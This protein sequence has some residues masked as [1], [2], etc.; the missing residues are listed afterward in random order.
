MPPRSDSGTRRFVALGS[1]EADLGAAGAASGLA[2]VAKAALCLDQQI[3]PGLGIAQGWLAW[4]RGASR[5]AVFLPEG[6]QFWM[7]NRSRRPAPR[8]GRGSNLAGNSQLVVLEEAERESGASRA[9]RSATSPRRRQGLFAIEAGDR[10]G[11]VGQVKQLAGNPCAAEPAARHRQPGTP[12]VDRAIATIRRLTERIAIVAD[13]VESLERLLESGAEAIDGGQDVTFPQR[14]GEFNRIYAGPVDCRRPERD[15]VCLP[16]LG[17][18]VPGDG[19]RL[20]GLLAGCAAHAQD[21]ENEYLRDQLDPRVWWAEDAPQSFA[22][23]CVP[24][25]GTVSLG[26]FVTDILRVLGLAPDAAIGYSLG[27]TTALVA[28]RA[29]SGRDEMLHR[30]RSSPLF[31]TELAGPCDAARRVWGIPPNEPVNWVA[32]I[33]PRSVERVRAG[34]RRQKPRVEILIKNTANE[35]VIGGSR[36]AVE[37]RL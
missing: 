13:G 37:E 1:I 10:A 8:R 31:Q 11:L 36:A 23:H 18:P 35:T 26:C 33:V 9:S 29:W 19:P 6:S 34:H 25:L 15:G 16:G 27:E 28:L 2:A 32:G 21:A 4:F 14:G 22:D 24:I 7:R 5:A 12:V 3:I 17:Q 20:V 30:L